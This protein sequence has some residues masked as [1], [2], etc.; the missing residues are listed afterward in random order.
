MN[1]TLTKKTIYFPGLNGVRFFA[2]LLVLVQHIEA[3]KHKAGY[4]SLY[5]VFFL[6][7]L[8]TNIGH[9]GVLV[10]FVL[11][12]FLITFL[13]LNEKDETQTI[14][15][16]KFYFRRILRIWP[17]YFL[18]LFVGFFVL[19]HTYS[20]E[21]FTTK[22]SPN[23]TEKILACIFFLPNYIFIKYGHIFSIG[24]LWSIGT[25]EQFYL[26][27]PNVIKKIKKE[28]LMYSFL[29]L[30]L[31]IVLLKIF[32]FYRIGF[33]HYSEAANMLFNFLHFDAMLIGGII[34]LLYYKHKEKITF[35]F[36]KKLQF[37]LMLLLPVLYLYLP[38]I[39]PIT[40][41]IFCPIYAI[42][43]LN[44][45]LETPSV[46]KANHPILVH[47][48]TISYGM[49]IYHSIFI[50]LTITMLERLKLPFSSIFTNIVLYLAAFLLTIFVS[51]ISYRFIEKPFLKLKAK[52]MIIK[53]GKIN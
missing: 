12:G 3:F 9:H 44:I 51:S 50:A 47:L 32:A 46:I 38:K 7:K 37:S 31:F 1:K 14:N 19:P 13:L 10:F 40:N 11:S 29:A 23:F 15:I 35:L 17:L 24:I 16:P 43:I 53:S 18:I 20:P 2:V 27:W 36:S 25:E 33:S 49:Y 48:G 6:K 39:D 30:L 28:N 8:I 41:L 5:D 26:I 52:F 45:A 21:Y 4:G 22:V 42:L 34:A